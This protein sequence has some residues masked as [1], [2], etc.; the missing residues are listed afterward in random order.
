MRVTC[1]HSDFWNMRAAWERTAVVQAQECR[2]HAPQML[3]HPEDSG[4]HENALWPRTRPDVWCGDATPISAETAEA[5]R[6]AREKLKDNPFFGNRRPP[7]V[8]S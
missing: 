1:E 8:S 3:V 2:R 5:R 4:M 6:V 7:N